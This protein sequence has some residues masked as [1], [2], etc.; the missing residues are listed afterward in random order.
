MKIEVSNGE[1]LDK[2]SILIIKSERIKDKAKL[3]N[4]NKELSELS[5]FLLE[6]A[7]FFEIFEALSKVNEAIWDTEDRIRQK[8]NER[9]FDQEFIELARSVYMGN[10]ERARLKKLINLQ[11]ESYF[12]EEKSYS[13]YELDD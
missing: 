3:A 12:V 2:I 1:L 6:L 10:D 9:C 7:D 8:E 13:D 11:S 4:V 5:S